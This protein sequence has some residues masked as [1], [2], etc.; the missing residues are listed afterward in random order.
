[1]SRWIKNFIIT[2]SLLLVSCTSP[3][4]P[5]HSSTTGAEVIHTTNN[6]V[7]VTDYLGEALQVLDASNLTLVEH[8][9]RS[10]AVKV[11]SLTKGGHGS[12]TYM[13]AASLQ[14]LLTLSGTKRAWLSTVETV[15]R[16]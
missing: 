1:M 16:S 15:R 4:L 7:E 8:R 6:T 2:A 13:V 5:A 12:G 11:R 14:Q 10:A 3:V 9:A